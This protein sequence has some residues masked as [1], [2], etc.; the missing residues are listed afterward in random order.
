M[1]KK[2][3][4]ALYIVVVAV[5]AAATIA[6]KYQGTDFVA[7][8]VYGAWWFSALW[9]LLTAVAIA[10]FLRRRVRRLSAVVLHLS[11]VVIL[12]GALLTHLTAHRGMLHL[13]TGQT[14]SRYLVADSRGIHEEALPFSVRL[15]RFSVK[16]HAGTMAA[17]DYESHLMISHGAD[18]DRVV[19]SMNNIYSQ[20]GIRLYQSSYDEDGRGSYM[21]VNSD[22]WGIPLTY[23]GYALLFIALVWILIDPKGAY[24][25]VLRQLMQGSACG[26]LVLAGSLLAPSDARADNHETMPPTLPKEVAREFGRL[27]MLYNDR[28]CPVQTY[29]LDFTKKLC[30]KRHYRGLTAEQVLT[31]FFLWPDE[32]SREPIIKV[33]NAQ[34]RQALQLSPMSSVGNF[35]SEAKGGYIVGPLLQQYYSGQNDE[36][37]QEAAKLDDRLQLVMQ[38][39]GGTP[40]RVFPYSHAGI[41]TWYAPTSQLPAHMEPERKRYIQDIFGILYQDAHNGNYSRTTETL[42]K[43]QQYQQR[44]GGPS[45]PSARRI[46]AERIY[47][48]FPFA[49]ILFM[50]NLTMG[51]IMLLLTIVRM[52]RPNKGRH[53]VAAGLAIGIFTLSLLALTACLAL[54]WTITGHVPMA[55]GYETMLILAWFIMLIAAAARLMLP[56]SV[57]TML[58]SFGF[59]LSGF[60]LLVSHISQMDPQIS[61]IMPVLQSPLLTIHV[62]VIMMSFALLSL[63]FICGL[64]GVVVDLMPKARQQAP[65]RLMLLSQL[66]LY[67]ALTTLGIG[68]FVGA[69]WANVSWG[70]YWSWDPKEVWALITFM[71]YA[72]AVHHRS[73]P[74]L[75][76]P[77]AYHTF[78]ILAFLS[79][80]MTYFGVNYF[81]GGMHS[82]A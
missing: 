12:A 24:R 31:G 41:I 37:H 27:N 66:F 3:L 77:K 38:L 5:M 59:L 35:F 67:P 53:P 15:E 11:F 69:I 65:A 32:W 30:G 62:S 20:G 23:L 10:W 13:R 40:F 14:T 64:V 22:P 44:F 58:L 21:A 54:R 43:M 42:K 80:L 72:V 8:H 75:R 46:Q 78:C 19:V 49:T 57:G 18:S 63:T 17:A 74:W 76:Q 55:N 79:I 73:L 60:F 70:T 29:A 34:L 45:I 68:I 36:L 25:Q 1:L 47:N 71:I 4:I 6:E 51:F 2:T 16:H 9:A 39:R 82:Y 81:L 56:R 50:V 26:L 7:M 33:K 52:A 61:H 48:R 28:I